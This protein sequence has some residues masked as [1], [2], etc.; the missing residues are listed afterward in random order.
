[1]V[2]SLRSVELAIQLLLA[3]CYLAHLTKASD[4]TRSTGLAYYPSPHD[5][6]YD[7]LSAIR[8]NQ[9]P[10]KIRITLTRHVN[11]PDPNKMSEPELS[12]FGVVGIGTPAKLFNVVFDSTTSEVWIPYYN[13]FPFANNLHYSE[14][15]SCGDSSTCR[16]RHRE[17]TFDYRK[18]TMCG[19]I[20]EDTFTLYEDMTKSDV[21]ELPSPR[22]SF[23]QIFQAIEQATDE[24]FRY[25]PYDGVIGLAPVAQSGSGVKNPLLS[26]EYDDYEEPTSNDLPR[27]QYGRTSARLPVFG[28]WL[29]PNQISR[30]GGELTIG[31]VDEGRFVGEF[32][33][34]KI[35]SWFAWELALKYVKLGAKVIS[36]ELGCSVTLDT[37]SNSI[38]GPKQDVLE[39]LSEIQA[40][41]DKESD[42][43][44]VQCNKVDSYPVIVFRIDSYSY[45]LTPRNY[46]RSF[47]FRE[48]TICYLTIKPTDS[49]N[50]IFGTNF[51]GAYYTVFDFGNRRVGFA[52]TGM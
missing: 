29:N 19:T 22:A 43:W 30:Y 2:D 48:N 13:W 27:G 20:Y 41:Y 23:Q 45:A 49:V 18:T 8:Q 50:W 52:T 46:I 33:F 38:S 16:S 4:L 26:F 15:Y 51:L 5:D 28:L 25:K 21:T 1:M 44:L 35:R 3:V 31:G 34:H 11:Y 47:R 24:Q 12:Y 10:F 14:G 9:T 42:L 37:G 36:C 39:I 7:V 40:E 17:L 6:P 32:Q